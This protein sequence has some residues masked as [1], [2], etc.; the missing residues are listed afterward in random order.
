MEGPKAPAVEVS[1]VVVQNDPRYFRPTELETPQGDPS[2]AKEK[3]GWV[4]EI[5]AQQMCVEVVEE[6]LVQAAKALSYL[7]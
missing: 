5:T 4:P 7:Y 1:D 6:D 3:L 2:K